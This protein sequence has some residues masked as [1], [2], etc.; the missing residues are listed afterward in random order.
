MVDGGLVLFPLSGAIPILQEVGWTQGGTLMPPL[1]PP[2]AAGNPHEG[3]P[4]LS[5]PTF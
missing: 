1:T 3:V 4:V 2:I 5:S